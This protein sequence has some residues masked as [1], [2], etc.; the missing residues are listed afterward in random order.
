MNQNQTTPTENEAAMLRVL[1]AAQKVAPPW[2]LPLTLDDIETHADEEGRGVYYSGQDFADG[3]AGDVIAQLSMVSSFDDEGKELER[4][5]VEP[6][7]HVEPPRGRNF[8]STEVV[9]LALAFT[10]LWDA[11]HEAANS[12]EIE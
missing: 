10:K 3:I 1:E 12:D 5:V 4:G 8:T 6:K 2:A 7:V 9:A 11:L